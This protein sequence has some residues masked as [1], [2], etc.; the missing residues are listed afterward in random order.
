MKNNN[1][2]ENLSHSN[3]DHCSKEFDMLDD[4]FTNQPLFRLMPQL[5]NNTQTNI[6]PIVEPGINIQ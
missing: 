2:E 5:T 6:Q 4:I 3:S 1:H